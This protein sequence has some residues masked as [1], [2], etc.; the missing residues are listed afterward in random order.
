[1]LDSPPERRAVTTSLIDAD[2]T[3]YDGYYE[4]CLR[5]LRS[6]GL[7]AIDNTLWSESR[8]RSILRKIPTP[9]RCK[10]SPKAARRLARRH[11]AATDR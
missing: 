4:R 10:R 11:I 2:K 5:L 8:R 1:M 6:G 7:I 9:P 3:N